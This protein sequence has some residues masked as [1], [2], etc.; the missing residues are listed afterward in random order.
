ME[1]LNKILEYCHSNIGKYFFKNQIQTLFDDEC[2]FAFDIEACST[3]ET[4]EEMYTYSLSFMSCDIQNNICYNFDDI[5][6]CINTL[7]SLPCKIVNLYAH[8]CGY[9][10]K[11][12]IVDYIEQFGNNVKQQEFYT[13]YKYDRFEKTRKELKYQYNGK[14]KVMKPFQYDIIMKDG[15]FYKL[16]LMSETTTIN[17]YDTYKLVPYSLKKCCSDFLGL[18]LGK[19]GLDYEKIRK[20][21]DELT[22]EE[23]IYI[24]DD[25]FGLS[26]LVKALKIDGLTLSD[27][28]F[29]FTKLTNSGQ[30]LHDYK[31][32]LLHDFMQKEPP[33]DNQEVY[34]HVENYLLLKTKFYNMDLIKDEDKMA[35]MVFLGLYP[36]ESYFQDAW[37]RQ[38]YFGG[39]CTV[40]KENVAKYSKRKNKEGRVYDV[41][42][43]YPSRMKDCLLPYGRGNYCEKPYE[44]MSKNYKKNYPLYIQEIT[45]Y[46]LDIKKNKMAWLQVKDNPAFNG[47]E[48]QKNNIV[49]GKRVT[50]KLRLTNVLLDLLF[51]CYDVKSYELGPHIAFKG[52]YNLFKTYIDFWSEIKTT[53][54]GAGRNLAKLRLNGLY[55]KFGMSGCNEITYVDVNNGKFEV[56]HTHDEVVSETVYLP[57]ASFI[58][59]YAKEK[60]VKAI[61]SNY[62]TFMY[63]DTDSIHLYGHKVKGIE[64][65]PT[66]FGAWD[67]EMIFNDFK[68]LGA[69]RYAEKD[70]TTNQ[71]NIKCCGLTDNIMKQVDNINVFDICKLDNKQ[72]EEYKNNTY[73]GTV[74]YYFDKECSKPIPGLIKSNK[75]KIVKHGSCMIEQPYK[76]TERMYFK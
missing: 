37:E 62:K 28:T 41:N 22:T 18:D 51:E 61:N 49:D 59:S 8:N 48:V 29:K 6:E 70:I 25:V 68:Y 14:S 71:W 16:T 60:L 55:G 53:Q 7:L 56:V 50:I 27:K 54:K 52:A 26:Y 5:R 11:P 44:E 2:N 32:M 64:I 17:F 33:F 19:D 46:S 21:D 15:I 20:P 38:S 66:K 69:K 36:T 76:I 74:Y 67:N 45:I 10:M 39:L 35:Q 34:G 57:M 24:Y 12:I 1:D 65:H 30:S 47:V 73:D 72:I 3:D 42:S 9:D 63:C 58:T 23:K 40:H 13:L 31:I 75:M 4:K 43:L